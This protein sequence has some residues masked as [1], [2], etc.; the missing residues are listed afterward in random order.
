MDLNEKK[1]FEMTKVIEVHKAG[2]EGIYKVSKGLEEVDFW[3]NMVSEVVEISHK[4][5]IE[6]EIHAK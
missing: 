6:K 1:F 5:Q 3:I 2:I 4:H